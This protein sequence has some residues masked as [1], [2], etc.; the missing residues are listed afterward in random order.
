[1]LGERKRERERYMREIERE[2]ERDPQPL[3]LRAVLYG[4]VR[5]CV[6]VLRDMR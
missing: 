1:V 6:T 5:D 3:T 2:T 4:F